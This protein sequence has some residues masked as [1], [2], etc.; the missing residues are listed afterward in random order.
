M[1]QELFIQRTRAAKVFRDRA[2]YANFRLNTIMVG[3][4]G[5]RSGVATKPH[6]LAVGWN[7]KNLNSSA[8][9]AKGFATDSAMVFVVDA[10][11]TYLR[12][13]SSDPSPVQLTELR[14]LLSGEF[15]IDRSD[16]TQFSQ[17]DIDRFVA[18]LDLEKLGMEEIESQ[19][20]KFQ[21]AHFGKR[22][23]PSLKTRLDA[24][25]STY[26]G[27]CDAYKA[28]MHLFLSW[29]NRH[30]HGSAK[31]T[32]SEETQQILV[33]SADLFYREHSHLD[34]NRALNGYLDRKSPSLKELSSLISVSHRVIASLDREVLLK[35]DIEKFA[36][37]AISF[38]MS[39]RS[40]I[41][42][43]ITKYWGKAPS[44]R[45][46]KL[47]AVLAPFGFS[48]LG[49]RNA[50]EMVTS[51]PPEVFVEL[52]DQPRKEAMETLLQV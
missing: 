8:D 30:V 5:V 38:G 6:D 17:K 39:D 46:K 2:G 47:T 12:N 22:K 40:T 29:R 14:S 13:I 26:G 32:I 9:L 4:E 42:R 15:Q 33:S 11:D 21:H 50:S 28:S 7:P 43:E 10:V 44:G 35:T 45:V 19:F 34:I 23:R 1:D 36:L 48:P 37:R 3:L 25:I 20:R 27:V 18:Q 24:L 52:A 31:D 49:I 51:I 16:A 41:E